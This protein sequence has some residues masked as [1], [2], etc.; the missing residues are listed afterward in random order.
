MRNKWKMAIVC[1]GM[2]C[3][4]TGCGEAQEAYEEGMK[5]AVTAQYEKS[6][7]YFEKAISESPE[8]AEYYIGYGLALNHMGRYE[9]AKEELQSV[10]VD[11]D[12]KI[13]K[14]NNKQIYYGLAIADS[15]LG[16]YES[17]VSYCGKALEI[18]YLGDLDC[19]I[20]YTRMLAYSRLEDW[21]NAKKDAEKIIE[22]NKKYADA[23]FS[24]AEIERMLGNNDE[25]VKVY[26]KLIDQDEENYDAYF[27][28]Y[29]QYCYAGQE[30]AASEL[31][32][33]I[34]ALESENE[35]NMLVM[36][37][38]YLYGKDYVKAEQCL[39]LAYTG[40]KKESKLYLGMVYAE[41]L[42]YEQAVDAF[43]TYLEE[44]KAAALKTEVYYHLACVYMA[45]EELEQ[46]QSV[47][48]KG[49]AAGSSNVNQKLKKTKVILL[50]KQNRYEEA[51][52]AAKEYKRLYPSD[53]AMKK[54]I[55]FIKTRIK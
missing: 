2:S 6:L 17:V 44:E 53:Q 36:G 48:E 32:E 13:S 25:A 7:P 51:L 55:S 29:D 47:V 50:E 1:F 18:T 20:L 34:F 24:L 14:E 31:L 42:M 39:E 9:E 30:D 15:N 22:L 41:Q 10:L 37:R 11:K 16:E 33:Q 45:Q 43:S 54:E 52:E 23:Y 46:A 27:A 8:Q 19:D 35:E 12:N 26:L 49:L 40:G 5:L 21:E 3:M 28:L 38:A 4:L